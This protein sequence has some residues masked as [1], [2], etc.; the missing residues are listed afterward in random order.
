M[1]MFGLDHHI[2]LWKCYT[3]MTVLCFDATPSINS[4]DRNFLLKGII[5]L[6]NSSASIH[7]FTPIDPSSSINNQ[8]IKMD[9]D[10]SNKAMERGASAY[11]QSTQYHLNID[12]D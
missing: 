7:Q 5:E 2:L 6:S 9:G 4:V 11:V 3:Y 10:T 8:N 12:N 1:R